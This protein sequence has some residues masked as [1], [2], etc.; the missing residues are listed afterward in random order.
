MNPRNFSTWELL[1]SEVSKALSMEVSVLKINQFFLLFTNSLAPNG[2]ALNSLF[3]LQ[4]TE[5][6][7]IF[8]KAFSSP[9]SPLSG[10]NFKSGRRVLD[11]YRSYEST[12]IG[13]KWKVKKRWAKET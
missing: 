6:L 9:L 8:T 11:C 12:C 5:M 7:L 10:R 4:I 2:W 3:P 1:F 13:E